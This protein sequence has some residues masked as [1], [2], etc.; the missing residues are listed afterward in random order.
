MAFLFWSC[1]ILRLVLRVGA[2]LGAAVC[3]AV[4]PVAAVEEVAGPV[5]AEVVRVIDG[6]TIDVRAQI[7]LGQEV[8]TRVRI[9]GVDTPELRGDC[10]QERALA[11]AA[12]DYLVTMLVDG[13]VLLHQVHYG[14]YAGRVV[15]RVTTPEGVDV[16]LALLHAGHGRP[17]SGRGARETWCPAS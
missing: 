13:R 17:Y 11:T 1:S 4:S 8:A 2:P 16:A 14:T 15:A 7:W 6:D 12:R 5:P 9:D 3:V 10:D